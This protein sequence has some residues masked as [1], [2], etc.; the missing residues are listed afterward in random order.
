MSDY[1][2]RYPEPGETWFHHLTFNAYRIH[3]LS[4]DGWVRYQAVTP[5]GTVLPMVTT[6]P[7]LEFVGKY[8]RQEDNG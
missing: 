1:P 8:N 4:P 2:R 5:T 7:T 3:S 6:M